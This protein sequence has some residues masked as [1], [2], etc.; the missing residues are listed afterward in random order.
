MIERDEAV[1]KASAMTDES[2]Y[3][4]TGTP[5]QIT[6]KLNSMH[7]GVNWATGALLEFPKFRERPAQLNPNLP[8]IMAEGGLGILRQMDPDRNT[9][10]PPPDERVVNLLEKVLAATER[11]VSKKSYV[12]L[13]DIQ[14]QERNYNSAKAASGLG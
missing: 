6:S 4:V 12:V 10:T 14:H 9:K 7:G 8:R 11:N 13:K 3:T 5:A 2:K 1:I